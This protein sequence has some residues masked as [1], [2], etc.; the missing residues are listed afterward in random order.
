MYK[1]EQNF[2][3]AL[4]FYL[5]SGFILFLLLAVGF[6]AFKSLY[7]AILKRYGKAD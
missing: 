1:D 5:V 7:R 6:Y 4:R 3:N 2:E